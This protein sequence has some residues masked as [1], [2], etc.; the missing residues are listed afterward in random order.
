MRIFPLVFRVH[1]FLIYSIWQLYYR[2]LNNI[3]AI[4]ELILFATSFL[5]LLP[6]LLTVSFICHLE[7]KFSCFY[8]LELL[9]V[10]LQRLIYLY[11]QNSAA[12]FHLA[13]PTPSKNDIK[14]SSS[15]H[16]SYVRSWKQ[17][18][19][20]NS[21]WDFSSFIHDLSLALGP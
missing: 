12:S 1:E 8:S 20:K 5:R 18:M 7:W 14:Y 19:G 11:G 9:A 3:I 15:N 6:L 13:V 21:F 16:N 4:L 10:S 2:L 17:P